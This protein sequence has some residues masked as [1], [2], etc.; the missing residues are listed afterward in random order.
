MSIEISLEEI[1]R[2]YSDLAEGQCCLSCGDTL[3]SSKPQKGEVCVDLGSGRGHDLLKMAIIVGEE[4]FCYGIDV[5]EGM[6]KK[7]RENA[8]KLDVHNVEFVQTELRHLPLADEKADLVV[9]N[10]TI[11]HAT[12]KKAVW[13]EIYRILKQGGRFV[14]SDIYSSEVIPDEYKND[15]VAIS[16]CWAGAVTRDEYLTTLKNTGFERITVC[17]ESEP[18]EK[19]KT[20]VSSF[21]IMGWKP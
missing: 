4:G 7:S 2:R 8:E 20:V 11:N 13:R 16:E 14:V 3:D 5:S 17:K 9:S 21:T 12:D 15:L 6:L 19:G 1:N 10:C 18:Y